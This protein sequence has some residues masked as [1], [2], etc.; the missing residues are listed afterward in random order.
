MNCVFPGSSAGTKCSVCGYSLLRDYDIAPRRNC[1]VPGL[2][3]RAAKCLAAVGITESRWLAI[4]GIV[5]EKPTCGC[6]GRK[7]MLNRW[8]RWLAAIRGGA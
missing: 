8:G 6:Q 1:T 5:I 3:D 7:E 2:G 4:K